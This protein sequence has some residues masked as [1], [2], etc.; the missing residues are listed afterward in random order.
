VDSTTLRA[1]PIAGDESTA[2][3]FSDAAASLTAAIANRM[4]GAAAGIAR[5]DAK[6]AFGSP[7]RL[8]DGIERVQS[9]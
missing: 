1:E 8:P 5:Q 7:V 6:M 2:A 4:H 3:R 9:V